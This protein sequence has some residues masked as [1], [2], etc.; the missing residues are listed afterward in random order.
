[1]LKKI[2]LPTILSLI[3]L[4]AACQSDTKQ[5]QNN[6]SAASNDIEKPVQNA[7]PLGFLLGK[8]SYQDI[9][10]SLAEKENVSLSPEEDKFFS[11]TDNSILLKNN[12]NHVIAAEGSGL[13]IAHLE[14][15]K[16]IFDDTDTL[17]GVI[18]KLP[19]NQFE[20]ISKLIEAKYPKVIDKKVPYVGDKFV[21]IE[22]GNSIIFI[23][24]P[25]MDFSMTVTYATKTSFNNA[26][27]NLN[28]KK[29]AI[30]N[31]TQEQL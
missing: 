23:E 22:V 26:M 5:T 3:I 30:Q 25:H 15:A 18:L 12:K 9:Q 19:K 8:A 27:E 7:S 24:S 29:E 31:Q 21:G 28:R 17:S 13:G 16:F 14:I 6:V 2:F 1:M 4:L 10:K 20:V 11:S